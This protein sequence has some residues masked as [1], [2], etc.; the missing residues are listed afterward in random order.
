MSIWYQGPLDD[1][2]N[3]FRLLA[4]IDRVIEKNQRIEEMKVGDIILKQM[5]GM[6]KL[7]A[8]IGATGFVAHRKGVSFKWPSRQR[9][10]GNYVL[11]TLRSDDTYDVEFQTVGQMGDSKKREKFTGIYNDQLIAV[12]TKQTGLALRL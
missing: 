2:S 3:D 7:Q 10:K 6:R 4:G 8:L 1:I 9:S 11:I 12:F 5:G